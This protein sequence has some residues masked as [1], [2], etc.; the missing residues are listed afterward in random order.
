MFLYHLWADYSRFH[1]HNNRDHLAHHVGRADPGSGA[2]AS[3]SDDNDGQTPT[4]IAENG[5]PRVK[6]MVL[7]S[8]IHW[9]LGSVKY[10]RLA[11]MICSSYP[12][13]NTYLSPTVYLS[14]RATKA[15]VNRQL[16]VKYISDGISRDTGWSIFG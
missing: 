10:R 12:R 11:S 6:Y 16:P 9:K 14:I 13:S 3:F 7:S 5:D 2:G 1:I 15:G 8:S 4:H